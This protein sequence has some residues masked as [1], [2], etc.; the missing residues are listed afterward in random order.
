MHTSASRVIFRIS[1]IDPVS[2]HQMEAGLHGRAGDNVQDPAGRD[3]RPEKDP[4]QTPL[5]AMVGK[6]ARGL[7]N[8]TRIV[9]FNGAQ[10]NFV[11]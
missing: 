6:N 2:H 11:K 7:P 5:Q 10:V 1:Y 3:Y 8:N 9:Y 4:V